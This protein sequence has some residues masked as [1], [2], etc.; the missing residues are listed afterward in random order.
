[1]D[2]ESF[3]SRQANHFLK[4]L[5]HEGLSKKKVRKNF[6]ESIKNQ[7]LTLQNHRCNHCNRVLDVINF[8]H[9][10]GNR[11]NNLFFNCQALCPN[12]HAKKSRTNN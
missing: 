1:M 12:C 2:F 7:V 3:I 9:I 5:I 6:S 11:S 4:E 10:D 8:D